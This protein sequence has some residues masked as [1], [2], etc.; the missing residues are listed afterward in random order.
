MHELQLL[1]VCVWTSYHP[2]R[3]RETERSPDTV[4]GSDVCILT[5]RLFVNWQLLAGGLIQ[6]C[7]D[8]QKNSSVTLGE[9]WPELCVFVCVHVTSHK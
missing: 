7:C 8:Q 3:E 1:R 5:E 4:I 2:D 9:S 6:I